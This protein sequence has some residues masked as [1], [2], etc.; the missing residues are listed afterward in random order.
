M[1]LRHLSDMPVPAGACTPRGNMYAWITLLS[2]GTRTTTGGSAAFPEFAQCWADVAPVTGRE[3]DKPQEIL[4]EVSH[5]VTI[6]YLAGVTA[7]MRINFEG[8]LLIIQAVE[9]PY[10]RGVELRLYCVERS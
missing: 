4:A 8:R 5:V 10:E 7:A 2:P 1:S 3:I 6:P 9:N